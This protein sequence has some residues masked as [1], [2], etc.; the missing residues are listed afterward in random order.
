M[1]T[2]QT[3]TGVISD[4]DP[5]YNNTDIY[6]YDTME[7]E[8]EVFLRG[9]GWIRSPRTDKGAA[10]VWHRTDMPRTIEVHKWH[11]CWNLFCVNDK[12]NGDGHVDPSGRSFKASRR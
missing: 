11:R 6:W 2:V 4:P 7:Q 5:D 9:L 1:E 8:F 10:G 3:Y 12:H